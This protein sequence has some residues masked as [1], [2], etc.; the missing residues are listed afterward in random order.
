MKI[1]SEPLSWDSSL[2]SAPTVLG[3]GLFMDSQIA[4]MF[5]VRKFLDLIFSL[6]DVSISSTMSSMPEI[7][8]YLPGIQFVRLASVVPVPIPKLLLPEF[9]RFMFSLLLLFLFSGFEHFHPLSSTVYLFLDFFKRFIDFLQLFVFS[10]I[11]LID[12]LTSS[13]RTAIIFI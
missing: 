7:L 8:T 4:W 5:C 11:S 2:H 1:F 3:F 9:L 13:L 6:T 12:L 10:W